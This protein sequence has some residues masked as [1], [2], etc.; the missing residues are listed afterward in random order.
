MAALRKPLEPKHLKILRHWV[1]DKTEAEAQA[2]L[3]IGKETLSRAL[4]GQVLSGGSRTAILLGI[5]VLP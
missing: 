3:G 5:G 2:L 1:Q 4:A